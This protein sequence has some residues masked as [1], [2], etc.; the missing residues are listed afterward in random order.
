MLNVIFGDGTD[1]LFAHLKAINT[2]HCTQQIG[3]YD[4]MATIYL[5]K[6]KKWQI[7][8]L[9]YKIMIQFETFEIKLKLSYCIW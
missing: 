8:K 7:N 6:V 2:V 5:N 4:G 9:I 3:H 1:Y